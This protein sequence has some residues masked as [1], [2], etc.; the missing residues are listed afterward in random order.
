MIQPN[1]ILVIYGPRRVGKTTLVENYL[2]SLALETKLYKST[3]ENVTVREILES[4]DFAKILPFFQSY[5]L[6]F[7]DEAQRINNVGQGLKI[8]VDQ[9]P[10]IKIIATGSSSFALSNKIGEPLVGR[11]KIITLFPLS[12]I[13]LAES[14]GNGWLTENL[15]NLLI[16]GSYPEVLT[17]NSTNQKVDYLNLIRDSHLYKDILELDKVKNSKKIFDLLRLLAFQVGSEVSIEEL[18]KSL[19]VARGTVERYLDSLEKSFVLINL[20]GFAKNLRSEITKTSKY[21]FYDNGIRNAII[22]NFNYLNSRNDIGALWENFLFIERIKKQRYKE[23]HANNYFWRTWDQKEVDM[24][25]ERDGKLFGYEFKYAKDN[26][27][28]PKLFLETYPEASFEIINKD[29]FMSFL[30]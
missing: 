10:G 19:S 17:A 13:E 22:S 25:E 21:Y 4:S 2:A 30:L 8:L 1:K 27:S 26:I 6:I 23:I 15:E 29:N 24:V 3:G 7:I 9:L 12:V 16:Y 5:D 28:K 14:Y 11:A 20:R 18:A